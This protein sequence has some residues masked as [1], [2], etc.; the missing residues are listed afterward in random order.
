MYMIMQI[1]NTNNTSYQLFPHE[2]SVTPK[3]I[4][5]HIKSIKVLH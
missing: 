5:M 2:F 3:N 4:N 1:N